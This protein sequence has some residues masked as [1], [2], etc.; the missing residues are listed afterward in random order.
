MVPDGGQCE[1][2]SDGGSGAGTMIN[3]VQSSSFSS[4]LGTVQVQAFQS[5]AFLNFS[6]ILLY[7]SFLCAS[8]WGPIAA[9]SAVVV[10]VRRWTVSN[11]V[12]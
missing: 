11:S 9:A 1:G 10:S 4:V 2:G 5:R 6:S 7:K 8:L 3:P 12:V